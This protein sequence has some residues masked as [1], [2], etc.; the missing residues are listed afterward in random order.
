MKFRPYRG[1]NGESAPDAWVRDGSSHES[2]LFHLDGAHLHVQVMPDGR[3]GLNSHF[4][5]SPVWHGNLVFDSFE[6]CAQ[7]LTMM[8]ATQ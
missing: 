5:E 3:Y 8:E 6:E 1:R 7:W 4:Y 2:V